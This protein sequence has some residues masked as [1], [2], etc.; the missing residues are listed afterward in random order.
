M[1]IYHEATRENSLICTNCG[2]ECEFVSSASISSLIAS[3]ANE[4]LRWIINAV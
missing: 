1:H 3:V 4:R 2:L